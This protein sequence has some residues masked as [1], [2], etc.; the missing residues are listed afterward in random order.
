[1]G[2][3]TTPTIVPGGA[4]GIL[5]GAAEADFVSDPKHEAGIGMAD[6]R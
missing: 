2:R 3:K 5:R 4:A 1:V 6:F